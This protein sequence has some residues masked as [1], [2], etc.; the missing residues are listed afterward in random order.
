ML[1]DKRCG[2]FGCLSPKNVPVSGDLEFM[3]FIQGSHFFGIFFPPQFLDFFPHFLFL[4]VE[5]R[6]KEG[7]KIPK[8]NLHPFIKVGGGH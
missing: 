2:Y 1:S 7:R 3:N 6:G 4:G 5:A 8:L